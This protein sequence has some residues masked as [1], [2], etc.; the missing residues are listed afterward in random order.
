MDRRELARNP[1]RRRARGG[2]RRTGGVCRAG[3][4]AGAGRRAAAHRPERQRQVDAAAADRRVRTSRCRADRM[5]RRRHRRRHGGTPRTAALCRASGRAEAGADRRRDGALLARAGRAGPGGRGGGARGGRTRGIS[6]A[7]VPVPLRGAA[8]A[9]GAGPAGAVAGAA[10][11]ARRADGRARCGGA[12]AAG[13]ALPAPSRRGRQ[14]RRG[15]PSGV[16]AGRYGD[17]VARRFRA[18]A[19][20]GR[21]VG[22]MSA[23][24]AIVRRDLRLAFRQGGDGAFAVMFFVLAAILFPFGIGPEPELLARVAPGILWV[25]ALLAAILALDRMFQPDWE[26]GTLELIRLSPLPLELAVVAKC[27]AHWLVTG[28]PVLLA[29]PVVALMLRLD[30]ASLPM[31]LLGMALGTPVLSLFG[32]VGAALTLGAR[33]GGVLVSLLVLPLEVPV[34]IFGV[35]A[36]DAAVGHEVGRAQLLILG[37]MLAAALPL[38]PLAAAAGLRQALE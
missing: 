36:A 37:A 38:C 10:L 27:L 35:G 34:L 17:A 7:A 3:L 8:A 16:R 33:R 30:P 20:S 14:H 9:G 15:E 13:G 1:R 22:G 23:F 31:L 12:G 4:R 32:S 29:T 6:R 26:D 28:L 18:G 24:L 19:R 21:L 25:V 5:E 2:P 11:A